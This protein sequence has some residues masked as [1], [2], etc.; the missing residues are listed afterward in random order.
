M[1]EHGDPTVDTSIVLEE[2]VT[3]LAS[4]IR[5][6]QRPRC[7]GFPKGCL[8]IKPIMIAE[9]HHVTL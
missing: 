4:F 2:R 6:V 7:E 5:P 1:V 8:T 3:V 9:M